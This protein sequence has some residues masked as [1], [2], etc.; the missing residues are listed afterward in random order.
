VKTELINRRLF[1]SGAFFNINKENILRPDPLLGP[2]G[3]NANALLSVGQARSRGFEFNVEGFLTRRW[4]TAFNYANINTR[5]LKDNVTSLIGRP[6]ANAPKHT[7]G[8]FTRYNFL[9]STGIGFGLEK[10]SERVEPFALPRRFCRARVV[11]SLRTP[12][13]Q[14][15]HLQ[16]TA[17]SRFARKRRSA[18]L[19]PA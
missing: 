17:T 10:A 15:V 5:I 18:S 19:I 14:N 4:Y 1:V 16:I 3:N 6:L 8:L 7:T 12:G 9:E 13:I 11:V 2:G